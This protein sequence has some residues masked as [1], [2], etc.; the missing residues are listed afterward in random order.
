MSILLEQVT[1]SYG[2]QGILE[3]FSL[4]VN[5]GELFVLLGS[6]GSGK[7]TLLRIIAGL[8]PLESGRVLLHGNDVT[9]L[10]PQ[11]R[12]IGFVFQN[13]SLFR[14]MT[15]GEN[16]SFALDIQHVSRRER[17]ERVTEL[18]E[19]IGMAGLGDRFP[20]QLSGGQQ[21]RVALARAL[22]HQPQVLL[23]DEPFGALDAKIRIQLRQNLRMI[24]QRLKVTTIL[25]THDQDE[26][27]ELADRIGIIER[28]HL[29]DIGT[30]SELYRTPRSRF[31]ASFLGN[32]NLLQGQRRNG[33]LYVGE[34]ELSAAHGP[35]CH[36][37][38][39]VDILLR[40]EEVEL[41]QHPDQLQGQQIGRGIVQDVVFAGAAQRIAI[42]LLDSDEQLTTLNALLNTSDTAI[43][44]IIPGSQVWVGFKHYHVL[45][46]T[47]N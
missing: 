23:L 46:Q 36:G 32:A 47:P 12:G 13:Y 40:P 14:H 42:R 39:S 10:A 9:D 8:T 30:P 17:A 35:D 11:K 31:T 28:G 41:A 3:N 5:A 44:G 24:Q 38:Q 18:L 21:Q 34:T 1:K 20:S 16:I 4:E 33:K 43:Q 7:S 37:N 2:E 27:F 19:L 22:A 26:A 15:V 25:V 6:S 29:L 45:P